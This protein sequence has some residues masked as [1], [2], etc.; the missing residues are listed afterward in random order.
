M[1]A[2]G[3]AARSGEVDLHMHSTASDGALPPARVVAAAKAAGL[4]SIALT[5]HD[6]IGGIAEATEAGRRLGVRVIPG[7]ELSAHD[8]ARE[9]HLLA[10]HVSRVDVLESRL[11]EF[12]AARENRA[13]EIVD[14]LRA[15]GMTLDLNDVMHEA[16]GGA[17]GRPHI[18]RAMVR[19]G[20]VSDTREAFDRFLGGG[21][22]AYVPKQRLEVREA[23]AIAHEAGGIAIWAHPCGDGRRD[24]LEPLVNMG[25]DGVEVRHPGHSADDIA[26]IGALADYFGLLK[27]GG[28]DWHG[29]PSGQRV[30][31]S[32]HVPRAWLERQDEV[33]QRR[34][35]ADVA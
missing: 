9:I 17:V 12:R 32:M 4:E 15:L 6:T 25:L 22:P 29:A 21:R 23:I 19:A 24:R 11:T 13:R 7:V 18:A 28:S 35:T 20:G 31:G 8:E 16:A 27:S 1:R 3:A 5:D 14:R 2:G 33:I 10:L 34:N 26:S 30:I